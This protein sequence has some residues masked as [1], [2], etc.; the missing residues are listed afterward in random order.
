MRRRS[1]IS[2]TLIAAAAIAAG[3]AP[4]AAATGKRATKLHCT[5]EV[6]RQGAPNPSTIQFGFVSCPRPFGAGLHYNEVTVTRAPA[7]GVPGAANGTFKNY[8]NRGTTSGTFELAIVP[9]SLTNITY[10]GTVTYTDGTGKFKHVKGRG[11]IECTTTDGGAHKSC[12][13]DSTLTG[14]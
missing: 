9:S 2:T 14:I 1:L 12:V 10:S 7:D 8:Y 3:S 4:G 6:F 5:I 13:V 11:T